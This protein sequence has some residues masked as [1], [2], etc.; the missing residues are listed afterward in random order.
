MG[1]AGSGWIESA[2]KQKLSPL[3]IKVADLLGDL[4][5]GIYHIEREISKVNWS[6]PHCIEINIQQD[7]STFDYDRLT[8]LVFLAH[9]YSVRVQMTACNFRYI[10]LMFHNRKR[11]GFIYER[12]P[13]LEEATEDFIKQ[14]NELGIREY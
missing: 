12:H 1:Y 10:K 9:W 6:D 11:E 4:F 8:R 13:T 3:G 2:T 14:M 5:L 7:F